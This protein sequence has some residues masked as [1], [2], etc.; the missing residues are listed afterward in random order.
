MMHLSRSF[1][2][3]PED[4]LQRFAILAMSGA[5]KSNTAAVMAE[6]MY[7]A[8]VP[9][10]A[11]DPKGDWW[12]LRSSRTGKGAGLKVPVL[13]GLNGDIPLEPTA[14]ALMAE[15]IAEERLTCILDVSEF[16]SKSEQ[17]K[18]LTAFANT[19]L[20]KNRDP[21]MVFAEEADEYLPQTVRAREAECVGAWSRMVKRGRFRGVFTTLIT[22][23]SAALNKDALNQTDTLI[24]MR[25]TA[26]HDRKA[27]EGWVLDRGVGRDL[28][29][30]LPGLDDGE[31]WIWS[32]QKW[33]MFER[34]KFRRRRTFD[35]GETPTLDGDRTQATLATV[36]LAALSD[37][38][39][40]TIERA[41]AD[42]PVELRKRIRELELQVSNMETRQ[43]QVEEVEVEKP[44]YPEELQR[45]IDEALDRMGDE[46]ASFMETL[47]NIQEHNRAGWD[48]PVHREH[49]RSEYS[50]NTEPP[51]KPPSQAPQPPP[52]DTPGI[53]AGDSG[54][55]LKGERKMLETLAQHYPTTLTRANLGTLA[56]FSPKGGTFRNYL[57]TLKRGG[58]VID[59]DKVLTITQAGFD[60]LGTVPPAPQTPEERIAVWRDALLAGERK[61][62]DVL[63]EEGDWMPRTTLGE[64]SGYEA[65]GGTFRNYLGKLVRNGL[66]EKKESFVRVGQALYV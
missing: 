49:S 59:E 48:F 3:E 61:M 39:A 54:K 52:G 40:E 12:G 33:K 6:E 32:P 27:I 38:M 43:P 8:G 17:L 20:K 5:G 23:R 62:L 63:I 35:S 55:L 13:G 30:S 16:D 37:R 60:V 46:A 15:T 19:L 42:D 29:D 51:P 57:G 44:V 64:R 9:W 25:V 36:D 24:P 34:L 53:P 47:S 14:G 66:A 21:L 50:R 22:Q 7:D 56:G 28:L 31:A 11:I 45:E 26:P 58:L 2:V 18:F 10:V 4:M 65:S 41:K 1:E